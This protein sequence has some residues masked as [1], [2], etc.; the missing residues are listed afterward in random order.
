MLCFIMFKSHYPLTPEA[1]PGAK[2]IY[3]SSSRA[4]IINIMANRDGRESNT[5][6]FRFYIR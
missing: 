2:P 1:I 6:S 5:T 4:L 3:I